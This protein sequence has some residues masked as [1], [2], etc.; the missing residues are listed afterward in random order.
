MTDTPSSEGGEWES[1]EAKPLPAQ[2]YVKPNPLGKVWYVTGYVFHGIRRH[3]RRTFSLLLGVMIGI[4]LVTSVFVWTDTG[5]RV[6]VD[7]FFA[8]SPFHYYVNQIL[9]SAITIAVLE[10]V[11]VETPKV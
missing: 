4:A 8:E 1:D 3:K 10:E 9:T 5:A 2:D 6:A 11:I 7:D